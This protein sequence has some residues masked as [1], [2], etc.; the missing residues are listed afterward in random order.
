MAR[1]LIADD[2]SLQKSIIT[3]F[4]RE[5]N[6]TILEAENGTQAYNIAVEEIPDLILLDVVMPDCNGYQA[7]RL[8]Q[9]NPITNK[10]PVVM[11]STKSLDVDKIWAKKQ[12]AAGYVTK[13]VEKQSLIDTINVALGKIS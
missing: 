13:P 2:S 10:I 5:F 12:G 11:V 8:L 3:K 1:I 9:R 6:H 7:I 4:L